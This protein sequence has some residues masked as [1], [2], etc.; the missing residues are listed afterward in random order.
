MKNSKG[1]V[2]VLIAGLVVVAF[3]GLPW[4]KSLIYGEEYVERNPDVVLSNSA[5]E[6]YEPG[7]GSWVPLIDNCM[8]TGES[9][10]ECIAALSAEELAKLEATHSSANF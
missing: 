9:R 3:Y 5:G 8:R 4:F 2:G 10:V 6:T 7:T 1:V